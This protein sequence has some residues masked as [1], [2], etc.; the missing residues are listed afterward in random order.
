MLASPQVN[1]TLAAQSAAA[2]QAAV[3]A[4]VA[5]PGAADKLKL[6]NAM[7]TADVHDDTLARFFERN[8]AAAYKAARQALAEAEAALACGEA[9]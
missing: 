2:A 6:S 1:T 5:M 7:Y 3:N 8:V 4:Q 9:A